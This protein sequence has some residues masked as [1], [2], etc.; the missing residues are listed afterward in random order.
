MGFTKGLIAASSPLG[1]IATLLPGGVAG[2]EKGFKNLTNSIT[3]PG[4]GPLQSAQIQTPTTDEQ[5]G[6]TFDQSQQALASQQAFLQALQAQGGIGN[7]ANVF[8]QLQGV[9]NG[10]GPNPAADML[11]Q[12]TAANTA[13]QAALMASQRGVGANPALLARQAAMQGAQ[14]QQQAAGQMATM[15]ANQQLGALGQLGN[16]AGQ[17]VAQQG[18]AA[19]MV[20]QTALGGQ[21]NILGAIGNQNQAA[22]GN[23]GSLNQSNTQLETQ[24]RGAKGQLIGNLFGAAGSALGGMAQGGVVPPA[25]PR[26]HVGQFFMAQGGAVPAM[27]SPGEKYLPPQAVSQVKQ[28]A[29]PMQVGK[30]VPGTP[31]VQGAK[32]SYQND[33]IQAIL[34][35]GGIVLPRSVTM[36]ANP[37]K[38]AAAFV[39]AVMSR[40]NPKK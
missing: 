28:G 19:G 36:G 20:G 40:Q 23:T 31:K 34:Q 2:I 5:A 4:G 10:Q 25:G 32:D 22:V 35:E 8:N 9:A 39:K 12:A 6:T 1:G 24:K 33:T 38:K 11:N 17:Q 37:D 16:I 14:N 3:G 7:Q 18:Q 13:N 21:Q 26:S 29:N 30:T 15:Q 27:L